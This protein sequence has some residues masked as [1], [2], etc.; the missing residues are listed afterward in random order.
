M[1]VFD[2]VCYSLPGSDRMALDDVSLTL[3]PGQS[4]ALMGANGSGK[5]TLARLSNALLLPSSGS[6]SVDGIGSTDGAQAGRLRQRVGLVCQDP[7]TQ[8]VCATV[9]E[10]AAFGPANLGM[11]F[12]Q[13]EDSVAKALADVGL[14]GF[15]DRDPNSLSGGEKQ[16]LVIAATL[17]MSQRYLVLDEPTSML[18]PASRADVLSTMRR[19]QR[20]GVGILHVTHRLEEAICAQR[21][22]VLDEG[23]VAFDGTSAAFARSAALTARFKPALPD[24]RRRGGGPAASPDA[25]ALE[26][27]GVS[28]GYAKRPA[29]RPGRPKKA[30]RQAQATAQRQPQMQGQPQEQGQTQMQGQPQEQGQTQA[31]EQ[32]MSQPQQQSQEQPQAQEQ[33][34]PQAMALTDVSI[35]IRP[36]SCTLITGRS[37]AG[38][39]TLLRVAAG[40]LKPAA[41]EACLVVGGE[42]RPVATGDVGLAF[43][44]P[45][46]QLFAQ[47]VF[48]DIAFGPR[49]LRMA[50]DE[51]GLWAI[52]AEACESV[53]LDLGDLAQR[54]PFS[55]S[56]GEARRC[57]IAGMLAMRPGVLLLDEPTVGLDALGVSQ[58]VAMAAACLARGCALAIVT[59]EADMFAALAD[60][61]LVLEGGRIIER[62]AMPGAG[63]GAAAWQC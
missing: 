30:R 21:V 16:R 13:I 29:K 61:L 40:I 26:L 1:L 22:I 34:Q 32:A 47:T 33:P 48:D 54:S 12:A 19:L 35:D 45:E 27:R 56:G 18:D 28:H 38:K 25:P 11:P 7:D 58:V 43:Q 3:G 53:G 41:G 60:E 8:I 59:H 39:S 15:E 50:A 10:E 62:R 4:I 31:Q 23:R 51:D 17:T 6:I 52:V 57:A 36:G 2:H 63:E 42:R 49:N 46:A 14:Q 44:R 55:L 24:S 5:S 20:S 9:F 37:G